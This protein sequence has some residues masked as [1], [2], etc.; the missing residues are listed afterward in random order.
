LI[1]QNRTNDSELGRSL[2]AE[3]E[4]LRNWSTFTHYRAK[5]LEPVYVDESNCEV[6]R[7]K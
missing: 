4:L 1:S 5:F 6:L 2:G 7:I 3:Y